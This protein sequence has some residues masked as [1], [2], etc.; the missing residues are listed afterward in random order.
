MRFIFLPAFV[1]A[2]CAA[3][4]LNVL[5]QPGRFGFGGPPDF[6]GSGERIKLED[7]PFE[8]GVA[9]VP[10]RETFEKL[11][12]QGP[13]RM[14][15]YLTDLEFV[16]FI[17]TNVPTEESETYWMNT[18][19]IQAHPQFMGRIGLGGGPG[20]PGGRGRRGR[21]G[22]PEETNADGE[23]RG[24]TMRGA[25]T[26][27]PR[28]I[29]PDGTPGLYIFDFQPNDQFSFE[30]IKFA[31]DAVIETMPFVKG[32]LAFH[33]FRE[34][35]VV[36]DFE[37]YEQG[38][39]A[40][41]FDSDVYGDIGFLP[42]NVA[43]S[44]GRLRM[45][46]NETRP[47]PRDIVICK[48][49]PNQMPRVAG[50]ISEARQTP[51]SHVNLRA[52]QDRVPNAFVINASQDEAIKSL[53]GKLV[54]YEVT[55][56]GYK[57]REATTE[58]VDSHFQGIRPKEPQT[59]QR[60]L[61]QK[62]ILP[63]AKIGFGDASSFGVKS[64]NMAAMQTFELPEGVIPDGV[65]VPFYFYDEFMK[66]NGFYEVVTK[67]LNNDKFKND[68]EVQDVELKKLQKLIKK[69]TMPE[70][71]MSALDDAQKSFP[72]GRSIRCRSSTNNEDL[73][74]FSGAGL[75]DSYTHHPEEGHLAKSIKQVYASLWNFRAFEE[76]E[77]YRIDHMH[78][79][80]GVL[81][82]P[83]FSDEQANGVAVTDDILYETD[84]NY[85]INTQIGEDLVTNPDADSS[86]EEILLAW[87]EDNGH[88][89]VRKAP[90][91][92]RLL[93]A[94]QL[95][96]L[97]QGLSRIHARFRNLYGKT[98]SDQFAMEIEFKITKDGKLSIKQARP[99]VF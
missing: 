52:I 55:P 42:L 92:K 60:D 1:V 67:L 7:L 66:H 31:Y 91:G 26:Y 45:M 94:E 76:R 56:Q 81:M 88:Q 25:V 47:S 49:L 50:V 3:S 4:P 32:K 79:A 61:S 71:M 73:A 15:D 22:P 21:G 72:S 13:M 18:E 48:T 29:S 98:N 77:F 85:Y 43:E 39:I 40:V 11:S 33:P 46:E 41:H 54:R 86:P 74:G 16:K 27:L 6:R 34:T 62:E 36:A 53:I 83:N 93:N 37:K 5:G 12:Y 9:K 97:R 8:L 51:L 10:D 24:I 2:I 38:K 59:P 57:I 90:N 99:W 35:D 20:G 65:A 68:R 69:G 14:D 89:V 63:L 78:A 75:Y 80:M 58:E 23:R 17:V 30:E 82:H 64:A 19:N 84:G 28:R 96:E 87:W 70:W 44:Y 95:K